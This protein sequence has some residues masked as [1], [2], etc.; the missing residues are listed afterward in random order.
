MDDVLAASA[1][2]RRLLAV[3]S[4][5]FALGALGLAA[6][7]IYGIVAYAVTLRTQEIGVRIALGATT[8]SI[9]VRV[10][11]DALRLL[12]SGVVTGL[13]AAALLVRFMTPLVFGVSVTDVAAFLSAPSILLIVTLLASAMPASRAARVSPVI[14]L[15]SE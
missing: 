5:T 9:M 7:G 2:R 12:A 11:G 10:V 8:R 13:I 14:A 6:I 4:L 3:L 15:R 1:A